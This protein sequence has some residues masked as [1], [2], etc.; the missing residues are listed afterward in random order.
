MPEYATPTEPPIAGNNQKAALINGAWVLVD[1]YRG[2]TW[3][4]AAGDPVEITDL[5]T[6]D[7]ILQQVAPPPVPPTDDEI[8]NAVMQNKGVIKALI[9]ALNDGTFIPGSN[10]TA[11]QI[12]AGIKARLV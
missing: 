11:A 6:P 4:T 8:Y 10:Y 3:Y 5:G 7:A 9:M 2:D 12:R 1:D